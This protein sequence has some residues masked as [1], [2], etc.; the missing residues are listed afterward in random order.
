MPAPEERLELADELTR[1]FLKTPWA[2]DPI[3]ESG[4]A[5]LEQWP[6]WMPALAQRVVT[7]F[8][9]APLDRAHE[10]FELILDFL[11]RRVAPDEFTVLPSASQTV[12]QPPASPPTPHHPVPSWPVPEIPTV[13]DLAQRLELSDGQLE[14]LADVR[15]LERTVERE[16][17]RNYRYLTRPRRGGVPRVIEAPKMRLKEIQRWILFEILSQVPAHPAAHGF[18][19]GRSVVTHAELHTG[20]S[21]VLRLDLKDFFASVAAG[22]VYSIW[23]ALGYGRSV[24]HVFTGLTT[25]TLPVAVWPHVADVTDPDAV[26]S[27]FR[28]GRQLATPHLP[29]GAPTSPALA[30]LAAFRL[31]RRLAGLAR[32]SGLSYS[33]YADDLTFSGTARLIRH[34]AEFEAIARAIVRSEGFRLNDDKSVTQAAGGRQ[35]VCGVVVNARTN[36]RRADYDQ[37]RAILHNAATSDPASQNRD[38]VED[39][40]AHLLGRISWVE[41]LNPAR[42][43]RLRELFAA[44]DWS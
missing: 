34:R 20:Q 14:W 41:A 33:R 22:R 18:V 5:C 38:H 10:L 30:N 29:Q 7:V 35:T 4:A 27:R 26:Q 9:V 23:R 15:G 16:Q 37:L 44:V 36:V 32:A 28:F 39:F 31:D 43:Q 42:G 2:A 24:A 11:E 1:A 13:R 21:A 19:S 25:N 6:R 12:S 8:R 17:L 40:R 3:A